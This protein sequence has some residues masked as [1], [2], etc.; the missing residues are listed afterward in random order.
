M[1]DWKV[2]QKT[3]SKRRRYTGAISGSPLGSPLSSDSTAS[4]FFSFSAGIIHSPA[5][6]KDHTLTHSLIT[7]YV[8]MLSSVYVCAAYI[9]LKCIMVSICTAHISV[10]HDKVARKCVNKVFPLPG[11]QVKRGAFQR[12]DISVY[13]FIQ[14]ER[15]ILWGPLCTL[16]RITW[17]SKVRKDF[18]SKFKE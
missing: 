10:P 2:L 12:L 3:G 14:T 5:T 4:V 8:V 17:P 11:F 1:V 15:D 16:V 7:K 13:I 18:V 9:P 6:T